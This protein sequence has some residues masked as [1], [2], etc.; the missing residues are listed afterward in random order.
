MRLPWILPLLLAAP[1]LVPGAAGI[2]VLVIAGGAPTH[3]IDLFTETIRKIPGT[4][5]M[6]ARFKDNAGALLSPES[7]GK[8]DAMLFYDMPQVAE[9]HWKGW[10]A[11]LEKGMPTVFMHQSIG[12]YE[13]VPDTDQIFGGAVCFLW[14]NSTTPR[15]CPG[16]PLGW[17]LE[18]LRFRVRIADP[19]HPITRGMQDFE[20]VDEAYRYFY[21]RPDVHVLLTTD[22]P[23][24]ESRIAWTHR[25]KNSPVVYLQL[26]HGREAYE[27][28]SFLRLVERS[29]RWV[30]GRLAD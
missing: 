17:S 5:V 23:M 3:D 8:F 13:S 15:P 16:K 30:T 7:A 19:S 11:L 10:M 24:N 1:P 14:R 26:G 21:V 9:P 27:N 4:K 25:Y 12:S 29:I 18:N 6:P 2:R 28:P 22:E 20:I